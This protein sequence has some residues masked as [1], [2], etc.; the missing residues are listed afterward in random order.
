MRKEK[1]TIIPCIETEG[2]E[3][4]DPPIYDAV[5]SDG[6]A[7]CFVVRCNGEF[8]E[9]YRTRAEAESCVRDMRNY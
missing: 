4:G 1:W 9:V 7:D 8:A 2:F 3:P 6:L 5:K